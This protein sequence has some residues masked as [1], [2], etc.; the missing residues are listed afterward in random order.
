MPHKLPYLV[1]HIRTILTL[2]LMFK[3]A[4]Y[5]SIAEE[6]SINQVFKTII[7]I[8][9]TATVLGIRFKLKSHGLRTKF[10]YDH[11]LSPLLYCL[12]LFLGLASLLWSSNYQYSALQW[13]MTFESFIFVLVF[14]QLVV[15]INHH[16]PN[17][18]IEY[19]PLFAWATLPILVVFIIGGIVEPDTF[20]RGMRGGEEK[21]L[22]GWIMNP[23]ELGMLASICASMAYVMIMN[24]KKR[25]A[26]ILM[27][28]VGLAILLMTSSRSSIIG[29]A[30]ICGILILWSE[31]KRLKG[32]MIIVGIIGLPI[33]LKLIVFKDSG[34]TEEVMSMT[35]RI[36]FW[37]ALL[38]EGIVKEPF[39][40][41]GFM[42]IN[43]TDYFQGLNTYPGKMTHN[44]FIQALM[45]LGFVGFFIV[46]WQFVSTIKTFFNQIKS[47]Y[48]R[49][50]IALFIP[51]FINSLTEF[52]IFGE[53]NYGILFYQFLILIFTVQLDSK[54]SLKEK[55]SKDLFEK[56]WHQHTLLTEK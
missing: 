21:R 54:L 47:P 31:N 15:C 10:A 40:G 39:F 53:A 35:G 28:G 13:L 44:T 14:I 1:K 41:Y 43:Y 11:L 36:P 22:G 19:A 30:I 33:L 55:L 3:I 42:R 46:F 34:G 56:R 18:K 8:G 37:N 25:L 2:V 9:M 17:K 23:N 45:N 6:R 50:F 24:S 49:F 5:F 51:I 26:P 16:F 48:N 32:V 52:G 7:R 12:Y 27:I 4:G 29:F 20:Y 38:N